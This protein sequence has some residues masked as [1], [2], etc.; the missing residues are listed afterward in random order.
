MPLI[1]AYAKCARCQERF[2]LCEGKPKYRDTRGNSYCSE[3]CA[4]LATGNE[5]P[6]Q[7]NGYHG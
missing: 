6:V 3:F 5:V 7:V 1:Y 2:M 4:T